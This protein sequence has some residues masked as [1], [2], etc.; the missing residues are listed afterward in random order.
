MPLPRDGRMLLL[1]G[2]ATAT[3]HVSN[4]MER[5]AARLLLRVNGRSGNGDTCLRV[6]CG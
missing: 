3:C 2:G 4:G 5:W 1:C 6:R